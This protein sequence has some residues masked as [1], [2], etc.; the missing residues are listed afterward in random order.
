MEHLAFGPN[1]L[2][3]TQFHSFP[4]VAPSRQSSYYQGPSQFQ[5]KGVDPRFYHQG[6]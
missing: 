2:L 1:L 5:V 3:E 4:G 6:N